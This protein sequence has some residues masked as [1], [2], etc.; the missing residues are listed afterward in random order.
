MAT[1]DQQ[2][3]QVNPHLRAA[4]L[5]VVDNQLMANDPPETRATFDRLVAQGIPEKD[6]KLYI[7]QAVCV[8]TYTILKHRKPF[9]QQRYVANLQ[10][11]PQPPQE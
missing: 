7:A 10:R 6:A 1:Q 4:F 5:E 3:Q 8:E 9:N 2:N 11:L